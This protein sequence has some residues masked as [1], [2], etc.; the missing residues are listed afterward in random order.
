MQMFLNTYKDHSHVGETFIGLT[1]V[2]QP[3]VIQ[4]NLLQYESRNLPHKVKN[5][6]L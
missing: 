3:C 4:Q 6:E 5:G 1:Y 2:G